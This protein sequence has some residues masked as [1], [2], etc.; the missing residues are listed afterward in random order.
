MMQGR[1]IRF[2]HFSS[3]WPSDLATAPYTSAMTAVRQL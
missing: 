1:I 2:P 3:G